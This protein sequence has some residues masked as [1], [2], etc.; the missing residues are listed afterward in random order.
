MAEHDAITF[1]D[2]PRGELDRALQ[3]LVA[4]AHEVMKTQ[5]RLRSLVNANQAVVSHLD[6]PTVLRTI[7]DAAVE[8]VD[9][10][11]GALGVVA[12][13]GGLE[14][15]IHVGMTPRQV[16]EIGQLPEG[17][18]LLGALIDD[19]RSI[20]LLRIKDDPRSVG[21]PEGHPP[22]DSFLGVPIRV[23]D[24]VYGNLYL[25]NHRDGRFSSEDEELVSALAA[26]AGIAID[27]AR[28][29]AET[30]ARQA[31][32]AATAD[33]TRALLSG[34]S[35]DALCE[36]VDHVERL[37]GSN[38][39]CVLGSEEDPASVNVLVAR[40]SRA[41]A[42]LEGSRLPLNS[43][44]LCTALENRQPVMTDSLGGDLFTSTAWVPGPALI[45][46]LRFGDEPPIL[47]V[48][49]RDQ[50]SP[51][52]SP[53]E[54]ERVSSSAAQ[55]AIAMELSASRSDRQRMLL[56][57]D[58]TRIARNLH[59]HVIQQLFAAGL[60][61]Q[62]IETTID[63]EHT[64]QRLDG[65]VTMLDDA[66]GQIRTI[67]FALSQRRG[68]EVSVRHRLIGLADQLS[69]GLARP[70][71]LSFSGPLDLVVGAELADDVVAFVG[72]SLTNVARHAHAASTSIVVSASLDSLTV[73]VEDDGV[74]IGDAT[75]RSGLQNGA[76]RAELHG[77]TL[78]IESGNGGTRLTWSVPLVKEG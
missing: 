63:E 69:V 27:N 33:I 76:D 64:R 75:R 3:D 17:H 37:S 60:E 70:A 5:G 62:S 41:A 74:G 52:Y 42:G 25:T 40:G 8:L 78:E 49:V 48:A 20:R 23:R 43:P 6:L 15:F 73:V 22:M 61:L 16:D 1:P 36:L 46:P 26:T 59:D 51:A 18:G 10:Q 50:G 13:L 71:S 14:Q 77:G 19:P 39:V 65:T 68:S 2:A 7:V 53:F 9:A 35:H 72:E 34:E 38:L 24:R 12:Q 66:I 56:L 47:L 4:R 21:F 55:V 44:L 54:L 57:E 30:E 29:F 28:L 45:V 32:S 31:W 67:I 58:R 11:Y